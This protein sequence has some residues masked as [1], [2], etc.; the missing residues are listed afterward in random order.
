MI[1]SNMLDDIMNILSLEP[2]YYSAAIIVLAI[3]FLIVFFMEINTKSKL[4]KLTKKYEQF[5]KGKDGESLEKSILSRF[6]QVD[7]LWD[8]TKNNEK[9][10]NGIKKNLLKTYQKLGLI[11]YDA[12]DGMGG[13]LSFVLVMLDKQ[14][15]GYIINAVHNREGCYTYMKEIRMGEA[16]VELSEEEIEALEQAKSR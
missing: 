3:L 2:F 4:K 13:L 14:D 6:E 12:Y 11:R 7:S 1:E 10:I 16:A 9:E 5:M 15:N 8:Q